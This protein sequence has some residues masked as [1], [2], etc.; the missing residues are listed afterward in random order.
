MDLR[1]VL[2][3]FGPISR[4]LPSVMAAFRVDEQEARRILNRLRR[5][6]YV[7]EEP[8]WR[9]D[10]HWHRTA[11]GDVHAGVG[12]RPLSQARA[13]QVLRGVLRRVGEINRKPHYLCR[14]T[15]LGV[16][17]AYLT[18]APFLDV[19]DLVVWIAPKPPAPGTADTVFRPDRSLPYWRLQKLLPRDEWPR[20]R[21]RHVELY[22]TGG[23][24]HL[25]LHPWD[26]P[27]LRGQRV[28]LMFVENPGMPAPRSGES[29]KPV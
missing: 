20:W 9:D 6:G 27:L 11:R 18:D 29:E 12:G 14:V 3:Q 16:F 26:D 28:R 7:L 8:A 22:L 19:L 2:R 17:G 25:I 4:T 21:E 13:E 5:A 1:Q 23:K 15:A 10:R 24:R